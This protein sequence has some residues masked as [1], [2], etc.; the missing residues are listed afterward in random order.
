MSFVLQAQAAIARH[1]WFRASGIDLSSAQQTV[2]ALCKT[3]GKVELTELRPKSTGTAR[4]GSMSSTVGFGQ[5]PMH[6]DG[7]YR[8]SPP[9]Y[10]VFYCVD[11]GEGPCPT[12]LWVPDLQRIQR[13]EPDEV[14]RSFWA[15][16]ASAALSF[17]SAT[18]E[19]QDETPRLRFDPLCMRPAPSSQFSTAQ[20]S[21]RLI[22]LSL[23]VE[24]QWRAGD[25]LAFENWR[26][27]HA[28][29]AGAE[30]SPSRVLLRWSVAG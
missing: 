5:Q 24:V 8:P 28:R 27:L 22:L 12:L 7:A 11:P 17:Y 25:I 26:C 15:V 18:F 19:V 3:F 21:A 6:T 13:E 10:L 14:F 20:V 4:T 23:R 1:G 29:G 9:R 16:R 2:A 30:K